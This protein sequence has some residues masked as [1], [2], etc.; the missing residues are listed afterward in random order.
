MKQKNSTAG[1]SAVAG[2]LKRRVQHIYNFPLDCHGFYAMDAV[3]ALVRAGLATNEEEAVALGQSL[4]R[5]G[6][7]KN[8]KGD[9]TFA[10]TR[11]FYSFLGEHSYRE[12]TDY[13]SHDTWAAEVNEAND[14]LWTKLEPKDHKYHRRTYQDTFLGTEVVSLLLVSGFSSSREDA[15]LLGRAVEH[16]CSLFR[17]VTNDHILED[18]ELFYVFNQLTRHKAKCSGHFS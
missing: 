10:D 1:L 18:K 2:I 13:D 6:F 9:D 11:Q 7:I 5:L 16:A 12:D 14:L 4:E 3:S 15:L 17:H 8:M